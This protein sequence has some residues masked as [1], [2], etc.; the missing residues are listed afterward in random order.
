MAHG[1][2]SK[3]LYITIKSTKCQVLLQENPWERM[4]RCPPPGVDRL[5]L[6]RE[7]PPH[8]FHRPV[9]L[10]C[11][12]CIDA[13][14][15]RSLHGRL[16]SGRPTAPARPYS[17]APRWFPNFFALATRSPAGPVRKPHRRPSTLRRPWAYRRQ[18][19]GLGPPARWGAAAAEGV[20][21][22]AYVRAFSPP[23]RTELQA[24]QALGLRWNGRRRATSAH[25]FPARWAL[26]RTCSRT[27]PG[28]LR[29]PIPASPQP[30]RPSS[31]NLPAGCGPSLSSRAG[32]G[33]RRPSPAR[34][35]RGGRAGPRHRR[36]YRATPGADG[37]LGPPVGGHRVFRLS[38]PL[39]RRRPLCVL[40]TDARTAVLATFPSVADRGSRTGVPLF[41]P[42]L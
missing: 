3:P 14:P 24:I 15:H 32:E 36:D 18:P 7:N 23:E 38:V 5:R 13:R 25:R 39:S 10:L 22:L 31:G 16:L 19:D 37:R 40:H 41:G 8:R 20:V 12:V 2:F 1:R 11:D 26:P 9:I 29:W 21:H 4:H 17:S 30:G 42:I 27:G 6:H 35:R 28:P 33:P 34:N